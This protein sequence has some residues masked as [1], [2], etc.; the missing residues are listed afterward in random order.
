MCN[1]LQ[2]SSPFNQILVIMK[3]K[4]LY[5]IIPMLFSATYVSAQTDV[6]DFGG[7]PDSELG[8]GYVNQATPAIL[9]AASSGTSGTSATTNILGTFTA[10]R[11]TYTAGSNDRFRTN[12]T[13]LTRYDENIGGSPT[14][15]P[16]FSPAPSYYGRIYCSGAGGANRVIKMTLNANENVTIICR[17]ESSNGNLTFNV[18]S[19]ATAI[20]PIPMTVAPA[21]VAPATTTTGTISEIH[22]TASLAGDYSFYMSVG[23]MTVYRIYAANVSG[24]VLGTTSFQ[25][26]SDVA[27]YA[28]DG[29]IFLSNIKSSTKVEVY[30]VLGA[31]VKST[32]ADADTSLD[33]NS[34]VYIVK[35][36][37]AEGE[38]S[39]KVIVQ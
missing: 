37:S 33:I 27:V 30:S 38:K 39:V 32:Q 5:L 10:G 23:K 11:L 21:I 22:F 1:R 28:K 36:K 17:I 31:L 7:C 3:K 26:Q 29:K 14:I 8:T 13:A 24:V 34:G 9:T 35:A 25:K 15:T 20:A 16:V 12:N 18:P 19:G 6:W 4:L 2:K